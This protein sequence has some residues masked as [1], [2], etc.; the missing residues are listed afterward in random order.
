M[1]RQVISTNDGSTTIKVIDLNE[2]YHSTFGAVTESMHIFIEAGL[3]FISEHKNSVSVL[4][5]GFGTG[6]NAL[7]ATIFAAENEI[8]IN[9]LGL[10]PYPVTNEEFKLLNY[11]DVLQHED[12]ALFYENI[13]RAENE[14]ATTIHPF[15]KITKEIKSVQDWNAVEQ[16]YD[17]IFFDAFAP[18]VQPEMWLTETFAKLYC[19]LKTEGVLV[20]YCCKG[21]VKRRLMECGF[22]IEKLPG[23]PGKR[24]FI[25]ATKK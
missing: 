17:V 10:E 15:F 13:F 5:V 11:T 19:S 1:Q 25:R 2:C 23:P 20:T 22:I 3:K 9:Y 14:A 4:E 8:S 21:I 16:T 7:L 18:E 12:S 6:L 24:E